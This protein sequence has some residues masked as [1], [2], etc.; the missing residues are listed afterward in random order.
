VVL[1]GFGG[2]LVY[3]HLFR[4][5]AWRIGTVWSLGAALFVGLVSLS[6]VL[7]PERNALPIPTPMPPHA[8]AYLL[9]ASFLL[10]AF[11]QRLSTRWLNRGLSI[12]AG[13]CAVILTTHLC[14]T[15]R[16]AT[17]QQNTEGAVFPQRRLEAYA[18]LCVVADRPLFGVGLGAYQEHIGLY[19]QGMPKENTIVPG[20]QIGYAV[21]LASGGL[22]CLA[23]FLYWTVAIWKMAKQSPGQTMIRLF[24]LVLWSIGFLT[25]LFVGQIL[26]ALVVMHAYTCSAGGES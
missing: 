14:F 20:T 19:Y 12:L 2:V 8:G 25:P 3:S 26:L 11:A 23:S 15:G 24:L 22:L 10:M 9:L 5:G 18:A 6:G 16:A 7:T 17:S 21:L 4:T 1:Y 13:L